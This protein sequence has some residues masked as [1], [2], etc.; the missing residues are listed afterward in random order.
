MKKL[1][2]KYR[3]VI[4][5]MVSPVNEDLSIDIAAVHKILDS[6]MLNG[7]SPFLLG[8]NGEAP[9]LSDE[10]K[11]GFVKEAVSYVNR[12][13]MVF[14]GISG[15]CLEETISNARQ[16]AQIGVD[17]VVAH[18]PFYF[19]LSANQM[20]SYYTQ[21]ADSISCHLILYNNP[22][23]VKQS[24]PLEVIEQLSHHPNIAGVKDSERGMERLNR[25]I[26]LWS[27]RDDFVH[28][29][30]WTVQSA[31]ALL[32]GSDGI[33][34]STGNF[35]PVLYK[36]LYDAAM[37][38]DQINAFK[39]QERADEISDIYLK[40]RNIS[41]SIPALKFIMSITGLCQPFVLPPLSMPDLKEQEAIRK[42]VKSE[43]EIPDGI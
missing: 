3:G 9:S 33:V 39:Y 8:T 5:P 21:L 7:V 14:A 6:F 30:G 23:T 19:P 2:K 26:E 36:D 31:Y 10:Q 18:L 40:D 32:N 16:Y 20:L 25:S 1:D 34:P 15:N 13:T 37:G 22:I 12:K 42:K 4:V 28:L 38:K 17:A 27:K 43:L 35:I 24:I 11:T 41:Q 29:L